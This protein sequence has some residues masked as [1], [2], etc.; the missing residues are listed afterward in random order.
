[1]AGQRPR[2]TDV[3]VRA[4]P[5]AQD[6][7]PPAQ[8]KNAKA[9]NGITSGTLTVRN[10]VVPICQPRSALKGPVLVPPSTG[11]SHAGQPVDRPRSLVAKC[12]RE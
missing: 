9:W 3:P 7:E 12:P 1:M 2:G 11:L 8:Q 10:Q 6:I 5:A 4:T